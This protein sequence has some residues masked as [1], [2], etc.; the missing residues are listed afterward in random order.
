MKKVSEL[1]NHY[2]SIED[3][4]LYRWDKYTSTKDNN[5]FLVDY[6]GRQ[7][8][9][10]NDDLIEVEKL[11]QDQ[12]FKAIDDRSFSEKM[13]KWS[14]MD[15]LKRKFD[16]CN[17]L[18]SE[19]NFTIQQEPIDFF[20]QRRLLYIGKLKD[21]GFKFPLINS[22]YEDSILIRDY[23][24]ALEGIRTQIGMLSNELQI[25]AKKEHV[26]LLKQLRIV[27]IGLGYSYRLDPKKI[28]VA[29]WIEELKLLEE[30][31]KKN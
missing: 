24:T 11:I 16:T 19:L 2:N 8:K 28:T 7:Q 18:L 1:P 10:N 4:T 6:D 9:I 3:L 25:D 13:Q 5:W 26:A 31:A 27:E 12:Y 22:V 14:K 20:V 15:W 23:T 17:M 29:E 21:F 30:K